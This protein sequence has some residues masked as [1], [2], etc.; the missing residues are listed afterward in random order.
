MKHSAISPPILPL[1]LPADP[2][3][4]AILVAIRRMAAHGIRDANAASMMVGHFGLRFR[5]PL[6]LVRALVIE[7]ARCSRRSIA[8]APCCAMRMTEDEGLILSALHHAGKSDQ[9]AGDQLFRLTGS[10]DYGPAAS[11]A[12]YLVQTLAEIGRPLD[13]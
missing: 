12:R 11:I 7:I 9:L 10:G 13:R 5:M 8:L 1:P 6:A 4:R 2:T 3:M